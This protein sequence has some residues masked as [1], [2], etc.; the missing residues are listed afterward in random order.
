MNKSFGIIFFG[1]I[2]L[3]LGGCKD[4]NFD[5]NYKDGT[6]ISTPIVENTQ[7]ATQPAVVPKKKKDDFPVIALAV[8][9]TPTK[10]RRQNGNK[11]E[12]ETYFFSV[13]TT[14]K[15]GRCFSRKVDVRGTFVKNL[16]E[17]WSVG[18]DSKWDTKKTSVKVRIIEDTTMCGGST[19]VFSGSAFIPDTSFSVNDKTKSVRFYTE[20]PAYSKDGVVRNV[21]ISIDGAQVAT[22]DTSG[23]NVSISSNYEW[24]LDFDSKSDSK[25]EGVNLFINGIIY[26][27]SIMV[28]GVTHAKISKSISNYTDN[29]IRPMDQFIETNTVERG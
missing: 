20:I 23:G 17:N 29:G 6:L 21:S 5:V 27:D 13:I 7:P 3:M 19:I 24:A 9:P 26:V 22:G 18:Y 10:E 1:I 11:G 2:F 4:G 16:S 15:I 12:N 8:P 28:E 14:E 25:F